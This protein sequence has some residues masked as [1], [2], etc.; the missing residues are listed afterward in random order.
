MTWTPVQCRISV[1]D[2]DQANAVGR[3]PV[4]RKSSYSPNESDCVELASLC[5][6]DSRPSSPE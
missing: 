1:H 5:H 4:W 3:A 6:N 2:P